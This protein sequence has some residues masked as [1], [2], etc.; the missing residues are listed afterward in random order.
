MNNLLV[1]TDFSSNANKALDYAVQLANSFGA[2]LHLL[3]A[4]TVPRPTGSM[5]SIAEHMERDIRESMEVVEEQMK[6]KLTGNATLKIHTTR[7]ETVQ[8]V[9]SASRSLKA[10]LIVMGTQGASGLKEVFMGSVTHGVI[11]NTEVPVLAIPEGPG[12]LDIKKIVFAIDELDISTNLIIEPLRQLAKRHQASVLIFHQENPEQV[13]GI[14]PAVNFFLEG[15]EHS[16]HYQLNPANL[17]QSL[18][19][20]IRDQ[21]AD[22]LCMIQRK[23]GFFEDLFHRSTTKSFTFNSPVPLLILHDRG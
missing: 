6:G 23:R 2:T 13:K 4:Y 8:A 12:V 14:D 20:F 19:E 11:R 5:V 18:R 3:H 10:D 1:P 16:F 21:E 7:G 9:A 15:I 17:Q 22:M